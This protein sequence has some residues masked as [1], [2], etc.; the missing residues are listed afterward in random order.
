MRRNMADIEKHH[1]SEFLSVL[2]RF[3]ALETSAADRPFLHQPVDGNITTYTWREYADLVRKVA[4]SIVDMQLEPE[5]KIAILAKNSAEWFISDLAILLAGHISVPIFSTAG[6]ETIEYVCQHADV[7]LVFVGKLDDTENQLAAIPDNIK[8]VAFPYPNINADTQWLDFL[9]SSP[10]E[11]TPKPAPEKIATIIYTSGS[12]GQPKGVV[13]TFG[14]L[15][16]AAMQFVDRFS[17]TQH[18]RVISYLPLAHI[19]ERG[20]IEMAA[21]YSGMQIWFVEKLDTFQRDLQTCQPTVFVSVPRLWTKF[22][23]GVL[24]KLPQSKLTVLLKIPFVNG[25]IKKKI[26]TGLGLDKARLIGSGSAP[27]S[28]A[29]I[30]WYQSIGISICEGWGMTENC[31]YGTTCIPFNASKIGAIGTV[32]KGVDLRISDEGEI[33]VKGQCNMQGYY[34]EPEKT[35]EAFT[36]DGYFRTGDK[37]EIDQDGYVKITGRLKD[38]FKTSKGKYVTPA[39]IEAKFMANSD[40]EQVCVTGSSLPQPIALVVLSEDAMKLNKAEVEEKLAK[41]MHSINQQLESHQKLDRVIIC[42]EPWTV[43]NQMLTPTLKVRRHVLEE[44]LSDV[45]NGHYSQSVVHV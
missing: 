44:Q 45:I 40:I 36:D 25:L 27:L 26:Q 13:H 6:Q 18:D 31:A 23:M 16:W 34:L 12:T 22:Q 2:E 43:E 5:S 28:P 41:Q 30:S 29:I 42:K 39:P 33:Q 1:S 14:S 4:K 9:A 10:F 38:I 11:D 17:F 24:N 37:G 8:T 7:K 21:Y 20:I 35:A 3:Y 32:H 19:T 15:N